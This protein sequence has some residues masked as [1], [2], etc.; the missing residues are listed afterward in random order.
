MNSVFFLKMDRSA[1]NKMMIADIQL[2]HMM[3]VNK[4]MPRQAGTPWQ[5][6]CA[7][8]E[9]LLVCKLVKVLVIS[10]F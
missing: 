5:T 8:C 6:Y 7:F 1:S 10:W 9:I 3:S 2:Y 4:D